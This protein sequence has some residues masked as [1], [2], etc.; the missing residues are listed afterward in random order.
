MKRLRLKPELEIG[1]SDVANCGGGNELE[2]CLLL[3]TLLDSESKSFESVT[4]SY[5][6]KIFHYKLEN[7][8]FDNTRYSNGGKE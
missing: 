8:S 6:L 5:N 3:L 2:K 4:L 7:I 1:E